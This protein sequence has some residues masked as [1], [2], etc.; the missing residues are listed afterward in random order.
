MEEM[1]F[2]VEATVNLTE[3]EEKVKKAIQNLFGNLILQT[4]PSRQGSVLTAET[5]SQ[6]PLIKFKTVLQN[7]HIRDA[8][9]K[10][11]FSGQTDKT[12]RFCLN[13]Q[14]AFVGHVSFSQEEAESPLGPI[15]VTIETEN[16]AQLVTWMAPK[17]GAQH[18]D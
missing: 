3:N 16:P 18:R 17:T 13:K 9:R 2:R 10:A 14:V 15:I 5:K 12:V 6:E 4:K 7:E 1:I 11:L 8:A